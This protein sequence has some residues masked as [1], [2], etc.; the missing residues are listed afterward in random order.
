MEMSLIESNC[1]G[2]DWVA[3]LG[4]AV[5]TT[6]PVALVVGALWALVRLRRR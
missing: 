4:A 1:F 6:A 3:L 2:N 5:V